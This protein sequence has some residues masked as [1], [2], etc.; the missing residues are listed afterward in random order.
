MRKILA[1]F[2]AFLLLFSFAGCGGTNEQKDTVRI[3]CTAFPQY[4]F[5][6]EITKGVSVELSLL[7]KPGQESHDY[8]PSSGDIAKIH[9]CDLFVYVGGESDTWIKKTLE[10]VDTS[11][12]QVVA[13]LDV[14]AVQ[15]N[16]HAGH[17]H[18]YDEHVWTAPENAIVIVKEL[19]KA[20]IKA[21]PD[22][23]DTYTANAGAFVQKL[24]KLDDAFRKTV[25]T[26]KRRT[27][28]VADRFPL[29]Y[30]CESYGISYHAAFAGCAPSVEP[31]SDQVMSLIQTVKRENIP[32]VFQMELS[33]GGVAQTVKEHTGCKVLTFYAC[34]NLSQKDFEAGETYLSLMNKNLAA[35]KEA[36]S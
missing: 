20:M 5:L 23:A 21:D 28:V 10:S 7:L 11:K 30:F 1:V 25:N 8:D 31:S 17:D 13:L 36:L 27:I 12:K 29:L 32:A 22:N 6:R 2:T 33:A 34:H 35:L 3:V 24:D 4:D 26:A 16:D 19:E 18:G 9:G 14:V 15:E